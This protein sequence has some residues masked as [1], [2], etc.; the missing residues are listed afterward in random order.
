MNAGE[1]EPARVARLWLPWAVTLAF[2]AIVCVA[3]HFAGVPGRWAPLVIG[4]SLGLAT[5]LVRN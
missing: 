5:A 3:V 1:R 2:A 4:G